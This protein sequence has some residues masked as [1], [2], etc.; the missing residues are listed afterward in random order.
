MPMTTEIRGRERV[1]GTASRSRRDISVATAALFLG[2]L[3]LGCDAKSSSGVSGPDGGAA[4]DPIGAAGGGGA[5]GA[6][7]GGGA[8][9]AAGGG[10][11]VGATGG[12]GSAGTVGGG[13]GISLGIAGTVG[14]CS[15]VGGPVGGDGSSP[16][17]T[18]CTSE[19]AAPAGPVTFDAT[20]KCDNPGLFTRLGV[21]ALDATYVHFKPAGEAAGRFATFRGPDQVSIEAGPAGLGGPVLLVDPLN[22]PHLL[23]E[24]EDGPVLLRRDGTTWTPEALQVPASHLFGVDGLFAPDG[25]LFVTYPDCA[26]GAHLVSHSTGDA[27]SDLG[28]GGPR[29]RLVLDSRQRPHLVQV[30]GGTGSRTIIDRLSTAAPQTV[31][32]SYDVFEELAAAPFGDGLM[33]IVVTETDGIHLHVQDGTGTF[34]DRLLTEDEAPRGNY[35][36][37]WPALASSKDGRDL[38][39]ATLHLVADASPSKLSE[40]L[41]VR[42]ARDGVLEAHPSVRWRAPLPGIMVPASISDRNDSLDLA[43]IGDRLALAFSWYDYEAWRWRLRQVTLDATK[44]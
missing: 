14:T 5:G 6:A 22:V 23:G 43:A 24:G 12:L 35:G 19:I 10:G 28:L 21:A 29:G 25:T 33:A 15:P 40:I 42:L 30:Q 2:W 4:G 3:V 26:G 27:W 34:G 20:I 32:T 17:T 31:A 11:T 38:W 18:V 16:S 9:G 36:T 44:L 8:G 37:I 13:G 7:G 39:L 41:V 1:Q